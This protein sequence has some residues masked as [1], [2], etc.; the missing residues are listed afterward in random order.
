LVGFENKHKKTEGKSR[1]DKPEILATLCTQD[2]V[3]RQI[4]KT[5]NI[6]HKTIKVNNTDPT[7]K[8][9]VKPGVREG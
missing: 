6:T 4:N 7:T 8:P 3:R 1:M 5:K 9:A 2:T